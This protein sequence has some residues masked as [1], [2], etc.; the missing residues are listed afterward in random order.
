MAD[1]DTS[2]AKGELPPGCGFVSCVLLTWRVRRAG[3]V[4]RA[5]MGK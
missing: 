5:S 2:H 1:G 4:R 3:P